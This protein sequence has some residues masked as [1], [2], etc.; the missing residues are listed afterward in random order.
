[1]QVM[2]KEW[3]N[4]AK[5]KDYLAS[6]PKHRTQA[7]VVEEPGSHAQEN[8]SGTI[9]TY[10]RPKTPIANDIDDE[11]YSATPRNHLENRRKGPMP[12][13]DESLFVSDVEDNISPSGDELDALLAEE[14]NRDRTNV[15]ENHPKP[16]FSITGKEI[17]P[18]FD[19]EME[20]MA[21]MD[22]MW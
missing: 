6:D 21:D 9:R 3:I 5:S 16:H 7:V 2:R 1:M 17:E 15:S 22:S 4:E 13:T 19:D 18:V 11:L 14:D 10:D 20:A 12:V 8:V